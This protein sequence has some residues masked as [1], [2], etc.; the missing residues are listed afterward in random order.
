MK[1]TNIL[2]IAL[3]LFLFG[4]E[5]TKTKKPS[6]TVENTTEVFTPKDTKQHTQKSTKNFNDN[7]AIKS[8]DSEII[9]ETFTLN[10]LQQD[11]LKINIDNKHI[12]MDTVVTTPLVLISLFNTQTAQHSSQITSLLALQKK[13]T[14]KLTVLAICVNQEKK[15]NL[16]KKY[17][18]FSDIYYFFTNKKENDQF[19]KTMMKTVEMHDPLTLPSSILYKKGNYY[20]H[21]EGATPLEM[22]EYNIKEAIH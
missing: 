7:D 21:Y 22:I 9:K 14:H 4:C 11:P 16:V 6:I 5:N 18:N 10:T 2:F 13:Y 19:V 8:H 20:I 12:T 3:I 17:P 15:E 1:K